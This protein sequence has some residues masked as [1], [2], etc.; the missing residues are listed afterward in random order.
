MIFIGF[1]VVTT[2]SAPVVAEEREPLM[3]LERGA[4]VFFEEVVPSII[5]IYAGGAGSGYV[6]DRE[7]HAITNRH[8]TVQSL[9]V[10]EIGFYNV[11]DTIR[12]YEN[13]RYRAEVLFEDP[14]LDLAV[15]KIDAPPEVFHPIRLG[16]SATM[17]P[18]DTVATFGSPGGQSGTTPT[19]D[20]RGAVDRSRV[21][22]MDTW[23]EFYNLNLGVITEVLDFQDAFLFYK[24]M[25]VDYARTGTRDYG[26]AVEYLFHTDSAINRG[27]SGGPCINVY[28]EAM[29]TNTWGVGGENMGMSVPV[30]LLKRSVVDILEY[31]RV[32]R[33]WCG[34][35]LHQEHDWEHKL[36]LAQNTAVGWESLDFEIEASPD[37][38]EVFTVNPY[39]PAYEA[40]IREGDVI[41][42][43]DSREF[44]NI[45]NIYSYILASEIDDEM[46]IEYRRNGMD[47][48]PA[49][50]TIAEK[51]TRYY[52]I[53][54]E[55]HINSDE[56]WA[57]YRTPTANIPRYV[58]VLTY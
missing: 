43:I 23:L 3:D 18:G 41:L 54:T 58:S 15:I 40:G 44:E 33:P 10:L 13:S 12:S 31:G 30:N 57:R 27:N 19:Y 47:M 1:I 46:I 8:V 6:I 50:I 2:W 36:Y 55:L 49:V 35:L 53:T 37:E 56:A 20:L 21:N 42:R 39:S 5:H 24:W 9:G 25:G 48:P 34:I 22:I 17:R 45:F 26:S 38:L 51:S 52:D 29:G 11:D 16:D 7:G 28:G 14:C 32:R 4:T